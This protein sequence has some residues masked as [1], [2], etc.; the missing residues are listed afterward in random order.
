M[1]IKCLDTVH[2]VTKSGNSYTRGAFRAVGS[3]V[4]LSFSSLLVL[5]IT[6]PVRSTTSMLRFLP[7]ETISFLIEGFLANPHVEVSLSDSKVVLQ[8]RHDFVAATIGVNPA[9]F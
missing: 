3:P 9:S 7:M 8:L 5:V 1:K 2:G 6:S 4:I